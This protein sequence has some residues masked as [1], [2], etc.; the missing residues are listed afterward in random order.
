LTQLQ[1]RFAAALQGERQVV[2]VTG[3]AGIGKT[4]LVDTFVAQSAT[5]RAL[6]LGRGQCIAHHG[7]GEAY[8]PILEALGQMGREPGGKQLVAI[9]EQQAPS[10]LLQM[11]GFLS[12]TAY[13][14]LQ[15]RG[16]GSTR[17][18]MLRELAEAVETLT[19]V[20]PLVLVLE[21]LHW[22][23][24]A[25]VDWLA[26]VARRR[27]PARV[28]VLG[29]YRPVEAR[30]REH[31]VWTVTQDLRVHGQCMEMALDY[32]SEATVATYLQQRYAGAALPGVLVRL[33]HQRTHGNPLFLVTLVNDL[34]RQGVLQDGMTGWSLS[35][36]LEAVTA[37]V[38]GT[39]RQLLE[40]H[41]EQ[42]PA[43]DQT[44]LE[45]ASVAGTEI[46][47]AAVAAVVGQPIEVVEAQC[48]TLARRGQFLRACGADVW[49][50]GTVATHYEF[51][52]DLYRETLYERVP[53]GRRA[54]WH[55]QI[56]LRLAT[57]YGPRA[58]E[59]AAEVAEHF[60][61][62]RDTVRA[63]PY[64][65]YAGEQAMQRSAHQEALQHLTHGLELLTTLPE[66]LEQV[67]QELALQI[68]L[69]S[70]LIALK[71]SAA[72]EVEQTYARARA[73]CAQLGETPQLFPTLR[74]LCRFYQN[75]GALP[76]A[77]MLG[78]QLFRLAQREAVP[79]RL[80]EAHD[81]LGATLFFLGDYAVTRT[82]MEQS[83]VLTDPVEGP[84]Q[85]PLYVVI[86]AVRRLIM[87]ANTLWCLGFPV[88]ARQRGQEALSLA[89]DLD[90]AY[91]LA[92]AQYFAAFLHQ[93]CREVTVVQ[94]HAEAL[95]TLATAQGFPLYVGY[96]TCWLGWALAMQGQA[97]AGLAQLHQGMTA[98]LATGQTLSRSLCL[99]LIAEA[100]EHAGQVAV[101]LRLLAE[102][103]IAFKE[104]GRGDLLAE[105]YRL[106]GALLL[107]QAVPA[108]PQAEACFQK[109]LT[110]ARCQQ[111]KSWEL[112]AATSLSRLWQQQGNRAEAYALLTPI[113]NWF[114]EGF[115]TVDLQDA[116]ALLEALEG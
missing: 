84:V 4:T 57:G 46:A 26:Y 110:I 68:P 94:A 10:W 38:P 112:R 27:E 33:L 116:K 108:V 45:A 70:V 114:T 109:A 48:A 58:R 91:S 22:S 81:A 25:T 76:T 93:R 100:M 49:P 54:R 19:A 99:V 30:V 12:D 40:Q 21:D 80:L 6:W 98:V 9:L 53:A 32:F 20:R 113:H 31:P 18:R 5:E 59:I 61:R 111:A 78:E 23:D 56:G 16:S 95:L 36:G 43:V 2:L 1:Q 102:A 73:L 97:E 77:R 50:D 86:P 71:G 87:L 115:D 66:T 88:Q 15:R 7:A 34:V 101:G 60:V 55:Q 28:L 52:H 17:E 92:Y 11:P 83:L 96:G 64:L 104:S 69:G 90:H 51:L 65:Q 42:L 72:P 103:L 47:V 13:E 106:Q 29:T 44:L 75:R 39:L 74:G 63:V 82:H 89:Q 79:T 3:E 14:T 62:G 24:G 8:L 37:G 105:A 67:Q 41:L 35:G 85:A 107:R